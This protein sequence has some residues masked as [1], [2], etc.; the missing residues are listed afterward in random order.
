MKYDLVGSMLIFTSAFLYAVRYITAAIFMGAGLKNWSTDL[1]HAAYG[2]VG[3][4]LTMWSRLALI[5]GLGL[6]VVGAVVDLRRKG[7]QHN[8]AHSGGA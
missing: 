7:A 2:Y 4:E 8:K 6:I 3:N 5:G 1:F